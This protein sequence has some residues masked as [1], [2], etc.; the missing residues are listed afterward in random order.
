MQS[1]DA[2]PVVVDAQAR[3]QQAHDK[4]CCNKYMCLC[5]FNVCAGASLCEAYAQLS[6]AVNA[7]TV[8]GMTAAAAFCCITMCV[9]PWC[10]VENGLDDPGAPSHPEIMAR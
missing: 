9:L 1:N 10:A 6:L 5:G 8:G 3:R 7:S 4:N 2:S